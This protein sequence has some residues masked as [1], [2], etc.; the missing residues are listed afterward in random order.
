MC[1]KCACVCMSLD[2]AREA[3]SRPLNKYLNG[4]G[5][6]QESQGMDPIHTEETPV[7]GDGTPDHVPEPQVSTTLYVPLCLIKLVFDLSCSFSICT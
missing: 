1:R 4:M 5:L 2:V 3:P 7:I 6:W